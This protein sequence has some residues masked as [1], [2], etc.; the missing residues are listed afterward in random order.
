MIDEI[1]KM[2]DGF[3]LDGEFLDNIQR[4]IEKFTGLTEAKWLK[5]ELY[6]APGTTCL[7]NGKDVY[8]SMFYLPGISGITKP[9][10]K[11]Y[12][13]DNTNEGC[14]RDAVNEVINKVINR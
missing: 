9:T 6:E 11:L 2:P 5:S 4:A 8:I 14:I 13:S 7:L 10:I 12:V 1:V 3:V